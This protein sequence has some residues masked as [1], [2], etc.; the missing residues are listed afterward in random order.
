MASL[1]ESLM[2]TL[3]RESDEYE[4]LVELSMKKTPAIIRGDLDGLQAITD[5]EQLAATRINHIENERR[6][7]MKEIAGVLNTDVETLKLADMVRVLERRPVERQKMAACHDRLKTAVYRMKQI[8]GHN[9][10]LI[11]KALEMT[12]FE[13]NV[14]QSMKSAPET[15]NYN[16]E[17]YSD[18]SVMGSMMGQFDAKQ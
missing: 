17:A 13:L 2:D 1:I 12:Q 16:R 10:E 4:A 9:R 8:N 7:V 18:G 6:S 14:Y 11:E 5:E 15:A 3:N